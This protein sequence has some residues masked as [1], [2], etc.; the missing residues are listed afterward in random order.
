MEAHPYSVCCILCLK[1][2]SNGKAYLS[3][4]CPDSVMHM[5][6]NLIHKTYAITTHIASGLRRISLVAPNCILTYWPL[7]NLNAIKK[8]IYNLV[9]WLISSDIF[10]TILL[11]ECHSTLLI[12]SKLCWCY[13]AITWANVDPDVCCH[14]VWLGHSAL[15][16]WISFYSLW[17][18]NTFQ[19]HRSVFIFVDW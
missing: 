5:R 4:S 14:M 13:Q 8:S 16:H 3:I 18:G 11:D 17:F 15:T 6:M 9:Y 10:M 7:G 19:A 12:I 2:T 1:V